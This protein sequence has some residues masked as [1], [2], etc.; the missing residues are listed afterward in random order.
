MSEAI[1]R[2]L[3]PVKIIRKAIITL[4]EIEIEGILSATV[5]QVSR[6][7]AQIIARGD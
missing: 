3:G 5:Q 7:A 4:A 1:P 2:L 6:T